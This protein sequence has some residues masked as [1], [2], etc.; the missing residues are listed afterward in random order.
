V[1]TVKS[2]FSVIKTEHF[3]EG[4][5][6]LT[7]ILLF[8][9]AA[10]QWLKLFCPNPKCEHKMVNKMKVMDVSFFMF[11]VFKIIRTNV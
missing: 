11:V 8:K 2:P 3:P 4:E 5:Y 10:E 7:S 1:L 9:K 6:S